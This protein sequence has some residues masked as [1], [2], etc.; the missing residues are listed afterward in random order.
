M[1][2]ADDAQGQKDRVVQPLSS[3]HRTNLDGADLLG[4]RP[5]R[6]PELYPTAKV[7]YA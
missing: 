7:A 3:D 5:Q 4:F 2:H 1:H 6:I